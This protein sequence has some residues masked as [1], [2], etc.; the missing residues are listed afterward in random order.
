MSRHEVAPT[1][2]AEY[3]EWAHVGVNKRPIDRSR[4]RVLLLNSPTIPNIQQQVAVNV[5]GF[6]SA[7][8]LNIAPLG[9][10]DGL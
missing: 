4:N 6:V 8:N 10:Y 5:Q 7:S 9:N 1:S 2:I 3:Y